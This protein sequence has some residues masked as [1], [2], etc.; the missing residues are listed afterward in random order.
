MARKLIDVISAPVP[1]PGGTAQ[2]GASIGIGIF[3]PDSTDTADELVKKADE[4]M[5]RAKHAGRGQVFPCPE[6]GDALA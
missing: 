4:C 1:V 6:A 5:Y 3:V 2:A